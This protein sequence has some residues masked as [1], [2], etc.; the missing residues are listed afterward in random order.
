MTT[1]VR[2]PH[3]APDLASRRPKAEKILR[4]LA[5]SPRDTPW[6]VL[7]V[8]TGSGGIAHFLGTHPTIRCDVTSVDVVDLRMVKDGYT[9]QRVEGTA[10]P[11]GDDA[12][13][14]VITNHVIEH[15]GEHADQLH[16]LHECRR[17]LAP[18]G[19][20]YLAVPN[21]WGVMEPHFKLPFLSWLP[22][23][24]RSPYV[25]AMKKGEAYDC[26]LLTQPG[27][28]GL[29]AEAGLQARNVGV[30]ALRA[31]LAIEGT[32]GIV[33]KCVA[34][35]PDGVWRALSP[36]IPTLIYRFSR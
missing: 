23:A 4:L 28:E 16:H 10:L 30:E 5:L 34:A 1:T 2:Q 14:V 11:F 19:R 35:V 7:E 8:G 25:R 29:F 27:I 22:H 3:I 20:G 24:W 17:V 13:D 33:R 6:R 18:D 32:R 36:L 21:R 12:F 15:V 31:M 26:E 9:W